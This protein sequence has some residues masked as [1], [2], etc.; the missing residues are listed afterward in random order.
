[1]ILLPT[2]ASMGDGDF[3]R[4]LIYAR[5]NLEAIK[6][7]FSVNSM[8]SGVVEVLALRLLT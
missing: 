4:S 2:N 7:W 6:Y 5:V 3:C 8:S 1:M